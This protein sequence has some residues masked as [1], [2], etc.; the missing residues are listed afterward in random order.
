MWC[1]KHTVDHVNLYVANRVYGLRAS[2]ATEGPVREVVSSAPCHS[3][4]V[5]RESF[6]EKVLT[7]SGVPI[8]LQYDISKT[9]RSLENPPYL[10]DYH[11]EVELGT[12]PH[13]LL[14]IDQQSDENAEIAQ[15]WLLRSLSLLGTHQLS[16]HGSVLLPMPLVSLSA[17]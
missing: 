15:T 2:L 8:T 1:R 5:R 12:I 6:T 3:Q 7:A 16:S 17:A 14:P 13:S 10:C 4:L 11:C 9:S